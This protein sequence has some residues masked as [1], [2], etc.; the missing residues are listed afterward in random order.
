MK[1]SVLDVDI[2]ETCMSHKCSFLN[3]AQINSA[4]HKL[5][6]ET[7]VCPT[8]AIEDNGPVGLFAPDG[9]IISDK[10]VECGLC[11]AFCDKKNLQYSELESGHLPFGRLTELQLKA[12]VSQYL[13][14]LFE[15]SANTNRNKALLF[16]GYVATGSGE[17][18]FVE[19]DYG[20]DS[21]KSA[22]RLLGDMLMF[23]GPRNIRNGLLVLSDIPTHGSRD[24][25]TL[26][27]KIR[28]F[29]GTSDIN[30][31]MTTFS[32]LRKLTL[33][34]NRS[35]YSMNDLFYNCLNESLPQYEERLEELISSN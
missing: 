32:I 21:L 10:C 28:S 1:I 15:F 2:C 9:H 16:D 23:S 17:E 3:I 34:V 25:Y 12:T 29:P 4:F 11:V 7:T 30:I 35:D 27:E 14:N 24:V 13:I 18:A 31:F 19:I 33:T 5:P 6:S 20:N 22:R 26:I 8:L